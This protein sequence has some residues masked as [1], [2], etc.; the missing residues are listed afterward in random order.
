MYMYDLSGK[1]KTLGIKTNKT[2]KFVRSS[3]TDWVTGFH[4]FTCNT[5]YT[6]SYTTGTYIS[7]KFYCKTF[8]AGY[9]QCSIYQHQQ[10]YPKVNDV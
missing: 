2:H 5:S 9:R 3:V 10:T 4:A 7:Q 8:P 6:L 1:G